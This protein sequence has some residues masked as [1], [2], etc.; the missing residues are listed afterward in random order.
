MNASELIQQLADDAEMIKDAES[1][2][3]RAMNAW[4]NEIHSCFRNTDDATGAA[5]NSDDIIAAEMCA[6]SILAIVRRWK[7]KAAILNGGI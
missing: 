2:I 3:A 7:A 4:G 1:R 6:E 5:M